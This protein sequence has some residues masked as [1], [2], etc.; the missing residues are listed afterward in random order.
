[1]IRQL[2]DLVIFNSNIGINGAED[3]YWATEEISSFNTCGIAFTNNGGA[4]HVG[5]WT[6]HYKDDNRIRVR[7]CIAF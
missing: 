1:M 6:S 3:L 5:P 4:V 7:T 2:F